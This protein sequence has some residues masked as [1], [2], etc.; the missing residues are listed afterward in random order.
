MWKVAKKYSAWRGWPGPQS[1]AEVHCQG[2][3]GSKEGADIISNADHDRYHMMP[4]MQDNPFGSLPKFLGIK[5]S[6]NYTAADSRAQGAFQVWRIE[7]HS[8]ARFGTIMCQASQKKPL[9]GVHGC[10]IG[11][12][13][14]DGCEVILAH[15]FD[16]CL[17][18]I[19]A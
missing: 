15:F 19:F 12:A 7:S 4:D 5:L 17:T 13:K 2:G 8:W 1:W 18:E 14:A 16:T 6:E 10:S 11:Q 9:L 3:A